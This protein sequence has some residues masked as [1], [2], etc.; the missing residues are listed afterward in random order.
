MMWRHV[1]QYLWDTVLK[2]DACIICGLTRAGAETE[3]GR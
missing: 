3:A 2:A 1:H